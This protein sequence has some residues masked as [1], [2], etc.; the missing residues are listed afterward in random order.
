MHLKVEN[1]LYSQIMHQ[2][3]SLSHYKSFSEGTS[4]F[5][6]SSCASYKTFMLQLLQTKKEFLHS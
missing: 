1:E 2:R 6:D 3:D 5:T 4:T